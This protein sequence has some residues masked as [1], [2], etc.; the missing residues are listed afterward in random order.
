MYT[1]SSRSGFE[2]PYGIKILKVYVSPK[3]Y[4]KL[5]TVKNRSPYKRQSSKS[6]TNKKTRKRISKLGNNSNSSKESLADTTSLEKSLSNISLESSFE[7]SHVGRKLSADQPS[8]HEQELIEENFVVEVDIGNS[9]CKEPVKDSDHSS[10]TATTSTTAS[11]TAAA[12]SAAI[13]ITQAVPINI[14]DNKDAHL[15]SVSSSLSAF[16][17]LSLKRDL[18]I[19]HMSA[20]MESDLETNRNCPVSSRLEGNT[21]TSIA[22]DGVTNEQ[23]GASF[24]FFFKKGV[25]SFLRFQSRCLEIDSEVL[26]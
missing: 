16:E 24:F 11:A 18:P 9:T 5:E 3:Q 23:V 26:H 14:D 8:V 21:S 12:I 2:C 15:S 10:E 7:S 13:T 22:N 17:T 4:A 1:F 6:D 20:K 25:N 19:F